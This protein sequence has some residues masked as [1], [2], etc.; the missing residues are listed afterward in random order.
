MGYNVE[1]KTTQQILVK[2]NATDDTVA[3]GVPLKN[4]D[5]FTTFTFPS[6]VL[7]VTNLFFKEFFKK[8]LENC[9]NEEMFNRKYHIKLTSD[10]STRAQELISG[11][12]HNYYLYKK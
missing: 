2:A 7:T 6:C 9:N 8:E 1:I 12:I 5:T 10:N 4:E 3:K 11:F